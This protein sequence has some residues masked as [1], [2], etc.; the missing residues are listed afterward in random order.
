LKAR[1]T[2]TTEVRLTQHGMTLVELMLAVCLLAVALVV[3]A[4][5]IPYGLMAVSGSGFQTTATG[6]AQEP[7]DTA[8]RTAFGSLPGLAASRAAVS[9]FAGFDREVLVTDYTAPADCG[10]TPCSA[11]CPTVG[12]APT[13]RQVEVRVYFTNQLGETITTLDTIL[14]K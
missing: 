7:I 8:K 10:G 4:A 14:A 1:D 11:S 2:R 13:C 12:G 9:G 3:V 5:A 6:L